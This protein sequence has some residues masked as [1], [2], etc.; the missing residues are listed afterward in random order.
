MRRL[1]WSYGSSRKVLAFA[2]LRSESHEE[3]SG[4]KLFDV[5]DECWQI[6]DGKG[7]GE[8]LVTRAV[9]LIGGVLTSI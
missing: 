5:V 3:L 2:S 7:L 1:F 4:V 6:G 9:W 8:T